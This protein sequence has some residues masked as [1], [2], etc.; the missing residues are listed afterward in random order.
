MLGAMVKTYF[1]EFQDINPQNI[2][3]VALTPCVSKKAEMAKYDDVDF[4]ITTR[5]LA[6]MLRECAIDF[7]TLEKQE[8]DKLL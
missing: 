8:F 1:A 5:E 7:Q 2:I 4:V 6:L 3:T